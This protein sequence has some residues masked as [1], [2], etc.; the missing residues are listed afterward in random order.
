MAS[1]APP[2]R[3]RRE[4]LRVGLLL[5]PSFPG[6]GL[7][8]VV[9]PL[10]IANWLGGEALFEWQLLSL[11]GE[12]VTA[13]NGLTSTVHEAIDPERG[14]D[15]CFVI[16]S[17]D[18]HK[19]ARNR[20]LKS[21]LRRQA[22]VRRHAGGHRDRHRTAGRRRVLDGFP[23]RCT[24]TTCRASGRVTRRSRPARSSTPSTASA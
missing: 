19:H 22:G 15:A 20:L 8:A 10:A 24:G 1:V 21:W 18:V 3:F 6:L 4:P 23:Q 12:P 5:L 2:S 16:A 14:W 17:F 7:A 13:S 9:E 11:D